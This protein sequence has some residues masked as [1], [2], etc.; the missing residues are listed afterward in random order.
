MGKNIVIE[1]GCGEIVEKKSRFIA[2]VKS[3]KTKEEALEYIQE[4]KKKY[5][6]ARH[7]C[8]AYIVDDEKRFSDDGEPSGT[9][10]K[11]I[12]DIIEGKNLT[13][14][15]VVITR[16]FGGIL[17]GTG[18]LVRAYQKSAIEGINN[19]IIASMCHG[20]KFTVNTDYNGLGKI[21]YL[22]SISDADIIDTRYDADVAIDIIT[23]EENMNGLIKKI[24]EL[25]NGKSIISDKIE[26]DYYKNDSGVTI[27]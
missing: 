16:Y 14:V 12:L 21:N 23:E 2:H 8:M 3:V 4:M 13:N 25:T 19:C 20:Y 24:T 7:N 15:V 1:N 10:G 9:A 22:I 11:P 17:L 5:Y 26:L 6:D 18:G 27:I